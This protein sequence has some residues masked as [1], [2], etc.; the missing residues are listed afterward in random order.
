[1]GGL[2]AACKL[3]QR[4]CQLRGGSAIVN[5]VSVLLL[6]LF[7]STSFQSPFTRQSQPT[8]HSTR[9]TL[10]GAAHGAF[11]AAEEEF[12]V[13]DAS[14]KSFFEPWIKQDFAQ[15]EKTGIKMSAVTEMALRYRECFGEVFRFQ[16]INGTLWVDHISERHS[17]W[18]PSRMGAGSLSAKGK[19]PYAILALMDTL[20]HHPGQIP[21]I[22]AVIQTSDFPCMLRQQ[23]GNTPPPP[24][25]GY[26][27]HARFVDIPF[28]DYT[29]WGHEYHRLVDEDGLLLFGW[30]KQFKLLSEKWREKEIASRKPQVIWRGRTEDKEYP[31]RDELRRQ[32][33]RCGDELR[34]EGFEEEAELFS[35][36]KPEVQLHDLGNYRYL[37]YIESDAWV[38]NLKQKLACG[39]VLM[40][41]QMEF[42]EF[43]TRAL[44]PG[45]HFVEVDSKD[46]CHD[47]TLK[48]QGMNAAIEKGS[49][50]ESMQEKDAESRRF[51]KET[52]Q[53]YTGAPWE[54]G[55]AGQEFLAQHV[56]MKDVRL[57]IRDAL[58]KYAS[59]QKFLPHTSW[60]AEC[61]TGEMLL[62]QF[63][64]PY[65][66]DKQV[67]KQ[68]YPW[69][70]NYGKSECEGKLSR[71]Q[72]EK[73]DLYQA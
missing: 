52:A 23:P 19:I 22:D 53:N 7:I 9:R 68:A 38:T 21:D 43:F 6:V 71:K 36:R 67:V 10:R 48:V 50:E 42:F 32:F 45:V 59:L 8:K 5:V 49:Q 17:G 57:Y 31:K 46:L 60:N 54:I 51:L 41:N 28:P 30:E 65:A 11:G 56:Q 62:E 2:T 16:I 29:Y 61:Y 33:A 64:F 27:S 63:G 13:V 4:R 14:E 47:A 55:Q 18:Y 34:R 25:F 58:R 73:D 69:L 40:S 12:K 44:Q 35:L 3:I 66:Y 39:S 20:R 1:M 70:E 24:V 37:M 15:W 26:N 72:V